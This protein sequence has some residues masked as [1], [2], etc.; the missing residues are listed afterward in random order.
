M[1]YSILLLFAIAALYILE[2]EFFGLLPE[3]LTLWW[4]MAKLS[5]LR[6]VFLYNLRRQMERDRKEIE[7]FVKDFQKEHVKGPQD[8]L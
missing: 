4:R 2:P 5:V 3:W 7:K 8:N 6:V 1:S